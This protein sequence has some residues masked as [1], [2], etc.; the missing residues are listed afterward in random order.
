MKPLAHS[1]T[2]PAVKLDLMK[3]IAEETEKD[4]FDNTPAGPLKT[5][6]PAIHRFTES[7]TSFFKS[8]RSTNAESNFMIASKNRN[9]IRAAEASS[10]GAKIKD[11]REYSWL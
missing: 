3:K 10:S 5:A 7:Q 4:K 11:P 6:L 8:H 2:D 9:S 1:Q